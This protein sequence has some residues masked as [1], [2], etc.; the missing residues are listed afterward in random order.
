M[1]KVQFFLACPLVGDPVLLP[2]VSF[3]L[4]GSDWRTALTQANQKEPAKLSLTADVTARRSCAMLALYC[5]FMAHFFF[6]AE[7]R[8]NFTRDG[9]VV[10]HN[11]LPRED[12]AVLAEH[13]D[14]LW[15]GKF[16]TGHYPTSG[17]GERGSH[18]RLRCA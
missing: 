15:A 13:Y 11:V 4:H 9:F 1:R 7:E 18:C 6:S 2:R 12:A 17:P 10:R 14:T 8:H 5:S 3:I 16:P